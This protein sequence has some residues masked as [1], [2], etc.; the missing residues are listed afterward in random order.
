MRSPFVHLA[1]GLV[2]ASL[3]TSSAAKPLL[4]ARQ[5]NQTCYND[6]TYQVLFPGIP[7]VKSYV[8]PFCSNLLGLS[9][10]TYCAATVTPTT[11]V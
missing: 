11:Y 9:P 8:D 4:A 1:D 5:F 2:L 10:S 6:G 7:A 3:L